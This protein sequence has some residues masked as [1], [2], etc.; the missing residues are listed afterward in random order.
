MAKVVSSNIDSQ[1]VSKSSPVWHIIA[2][3]AI[4]GLL[5]YVLTLY[6]S[7]FVG[8]ASVAGDIA[9]I[10]VATVGIIVMLNLGMARPLLVAVASAISLWGLSKLTDGLGWF[11]AM[12]WSVLIYSLAYFLFSWLTR[13]K[14]IIPVLIAVV[15]IVIIVRLTITP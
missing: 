10:I 12:V 13:Y 5:Y 1:P 14:K 3:G 4:L 8:L 7:R 11:E 2:V 9:T 6:L 15:A